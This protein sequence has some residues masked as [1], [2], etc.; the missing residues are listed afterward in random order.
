MRAFLSVG[1]I[2]SMLAMT[3]AGPA[4]AFT[5][6]TSPKL[7]SAGTS[8]V[9][10]VQFR[11][12]GGGGFHR[13]GGFRGGRHYGGGYRGGRGYGG[14]AAIGAGIAGLAAGALIGGAIANSQPAY[15]YG[16]YGDGG[17]YGAPAPVYVDPGYAQA[18]VYADQG[19]DTE[20]YC[21]Q[22]FKSYDPSSGTY[23]GYDGQ[24]HPCP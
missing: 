13:G 23:L 16:G 15:G 4:S 1:V 22:R 19:G 9:E 14:G 17:Y 6:D 10:Q 11:R 7:A 5:I 12:H 3:A 21:M 8:N 2:G 24:R 18:P 20:Q